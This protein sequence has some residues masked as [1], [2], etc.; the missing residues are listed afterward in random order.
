MVKICLDDHCFELSPHL[1]LLEGLEAEGMEWP[2]Q[3]RSGKCQ[4]CLVRVLDGDVPDEARRGL[5][6]SLAMQGLAMACVCYP[7]GDLKIAAT[8]AAV[9]KTGVEVIGLERLT[10]EIL[11]VRL[12][13][14]QVMSY[15]AGQ[16]IH[17]VRPGDGLKRS[18]SIASVPSTDAA[19]LLLHVRLMPGGAMSA[20]LF[21]E[22]ATGDRLE[23]E[24][25][26]G[27][28]FYV[29]GDVNQPLLMVAT[30]TGL[31]PLWGV[32]RDALQQGHQGPIHLYH[33][34]RSP[35]GLYLV[36]ALWQL[37]VAHPQLH[38]YPCL[39]SADNSLEG[40]HAGRASDLALEHHAT[41]KGWR[42]YLCGQPDMVTLLRRKT[43]I[44]GAAMQDIHMDAFTS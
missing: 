33:G 23:V 39:S 35:D 3:C 41:L 36:D 30:G 31:A 20:W 40:C 25:P 27:D 4:T 37:A 24:G 17:L 21:D 12:R 8:Y 15:R 13:P 5:K 22:V 7:E 11:E 43:F 32:L 26:F 18:Y 29:P 1:S 10:P 42:I 16:F 2:N 44:A 38:Y 14:D 6:P 9:M 34:S 28:C 19:D